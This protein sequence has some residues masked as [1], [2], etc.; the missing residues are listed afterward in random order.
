MKVTI[1]EEECTGCGVCE[2]MCPDVFKVGEDNKAHVLRSEGC[3]GCDCNEV[4]E[5]CPSEAITVEKT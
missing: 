2:S 4:A 5:S 3:D 1:N